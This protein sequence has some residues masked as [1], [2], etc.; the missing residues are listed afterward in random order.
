[1]TEKMSNGPTPSEN[2]ACNKKFS[3]QNSLRSIGLYFLR[4]QA[5][6]KRSMLQ[7]IT[8]TAMAVIAMVVAI[9]IPFDPMTVASGVYR[10][11]RTSVNTGDQ[12]VYYKDGKTASVAVIL[13]PSGHASISTNGKKGNSYSKKTRN[14]GPT[15]GLP[16]NPSECVAGS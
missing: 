16:L 8:A 2:V 10:H 14:T 1:M 15:A 13:S 7:F 12:V 9:R 5:S 6:Q 3:G 4:Q 11:G